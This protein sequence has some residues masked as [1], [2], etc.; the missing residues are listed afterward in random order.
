MSQKFLQILGVAI[1]ACLAIWAAKVLLA[2]FV[3]AIFVTIAVV[4]I[5]VVAMLFVGRVLGLWT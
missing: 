1:L 3:P 4:V 5:V 2:G